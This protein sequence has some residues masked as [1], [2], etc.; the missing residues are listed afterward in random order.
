MSELAQRL[1]RLVLNLDHMGMR[2]EQALVD[3]LNA[4]ADGDGDAGRAVNKRDALVD[5]QEVEIEQECIRLLALY[6]P[7]AVDLRTICMVIRV[8]GDLE[9]MADLAASIG[10]RVRK[11]VDHQLDL[12]RYPGFEHLAQATLDVVGK[13]V[14][15]LSLADTSI[16]QRVME[17]DKLIDKGYKHFV[18]TVLA[19]QD[20]HIGGAE[21]AMILINLAKALE[22]IGDHCTNI[23][24]DVVFLRTGDIIR[25]AGAFEE[26]P[27]QQPATGQMD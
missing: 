2:V 8:I 12:T 18:Q 5:R 17:D 25:H 7:A 11:V 15:M 20:Q 4:L 22:R 24:E 10:K 27:P 13:T 23:A 21:H 6:Q 1:D 3:A 9:R 19:D 26:T 14:R 16:A